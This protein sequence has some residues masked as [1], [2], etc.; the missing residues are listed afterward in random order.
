MKRQNELTVFFNH[1]IILLSFFLSVT[2]TGAVVREKKKKIL[3]CSSRVAKWN[4]LYT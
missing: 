1:P 3:T 2:T 4:N